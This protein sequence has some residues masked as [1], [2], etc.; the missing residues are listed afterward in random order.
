M[1]RQ[2]EAVTGERGE[3]GRERGRKGEVMSAADIRE[4]LT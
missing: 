2:G 3:E 1:F 4:V